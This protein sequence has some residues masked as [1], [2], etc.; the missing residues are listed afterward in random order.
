[1]SWPKNV[2][3]NVLKFIFLQFL[4]VV[5][6]I[7]LKTRT[8]F[9]IQKPTSLSLNRQPGAHCLVKTGGGHILEHMKTLLNNKQLKGLISDHVEKKIEIIL[10]MS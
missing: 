1:M 2:L 3:K 5:Q 8:Y 10:E 6:E 4:I 7:N 9:S